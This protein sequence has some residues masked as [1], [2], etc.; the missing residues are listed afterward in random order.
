MTPFQQ[1]R[2]RRRLRRIRNQY[3]P[4]PTYA[5]A[6]WAVASYLAA[7]VTLGIVYGAVHY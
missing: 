2:V 5:W 1:L 6:Y 3:S 4:P 7:W